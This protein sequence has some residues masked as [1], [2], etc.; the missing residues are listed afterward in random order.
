MNDRNDDGVS[1]RVA[2][3]ALGGIA[4]ATLPDCT[5][6]KVRSR[7]EARSMTA[8]TARTPVVYLPHGGG[9]WPFVDVGLGDPAELRSL[10]LKDE[11][12]RRVR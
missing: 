2:L 10:T 5:A 7:S 1:R 11:W 4:L 12:V 3:A 9:P 6:E 8:R